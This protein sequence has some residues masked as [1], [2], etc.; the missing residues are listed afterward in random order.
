[1][2]ILLVALVGLAVPV[3]DLLRPSGYRRL[4]VRNLRRRRGEALLVVGGSLLGTAIITAS[5]LV[6]DTFTASIRD[7]ARTQ[8]GPIDERVVVDHADQLDRVERLVAD[9]LP[10]GSDGV[11]ASR[12]IEASVATTGPDRRAE[13]SRQ[14]MV[15]DFAAARRFGGDPSSTGL[16]NAGPTPGAGQAVLNTG[17]AHDLHVRSGARIHVYAYG[18]ETTLRVRQVLPEVGLAGSADLF[19]GP[20]TLDHLARSPFPVGADPPHAEVLVSNRGGVFSG[21]GRSRAVA[22]E[23]R[24]R[25]SAVPGTTVRLSKSDLLKSAADQG[26]STGQLFT[27]IGVFSVL[28]GILLLVNLFVMLAEERKTEMGILRALGY[29][30][31]HLMRLFAAEG[32]LYAVVAAAC[33]AGL[34]VGVGEAIVAITQGIFNGSGDVALHFSA[35]TNSLLEGAGI[36]LLMSLATVWITS[37]RIARLNVIAAIR[38]LP[39]PGHRRRGRRALIL[40]SLGVVVGLLTFL[41]G[42]LGS[43]P[44]PTLVG[45]MLACFAAMPVAAQLLPRRA[46]VPVLAAGALAWGAFVFTL[47]PGATAGAGIPVFVTQG[48]LLVGAAVTL[49]SQAD[50]LWGALA[51]LLGRRGKGLAARLGLAYPLARAFRTGMLLAMYALVMFT[52]TFLAV[53]S[54]VFEA[55]EPKTVTA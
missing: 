45:P 50:R 24:H 26:Q 53:F 17:L 16:A 46:A 48:I 14:L 2:L 11:L 30:R 5:F 19:V 6:G 36:G 22:R 37:A 33:G 43:S 21:A 54:A 20:S 9:P 7:T 29:R 10:A 51:D 4:A 49:L 55:Q 40:G 39:D 44:L 28:A 31:S 13:P 1:M 47:L 12:W 25:V 32:A 34:G 3:W 15:Y 18:R 35:P 23:L 8:L 52:L 42:F 38:D 41:G 27:G